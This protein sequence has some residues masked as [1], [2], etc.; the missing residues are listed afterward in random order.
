MS[1]ARKL[2][3]QLAQSTKTRYKRDGVTPARYNAYNKLSSRKVRALAKAGVDRKAYL[4]APK[5]TT[6]VDLKREP[7]RFKGTPGKMW[8][9]RIRA[10]ARR[11][12]NKPDGERGGAFRPTDE[13]FLFWQE[14]QKVRG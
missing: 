10:R 9:D 14:Y 11:Y 12:A 2:W 7:E 4:K 5:G 13:P 6:L 1:V 8:D 3:S